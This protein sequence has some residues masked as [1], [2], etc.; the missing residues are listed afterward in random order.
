MT[1]TVLY[2]AV[3]QVLVIILMFLISPKIYTIFGYKLRGF[4]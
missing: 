3:T 4:K 2:Y 1:V